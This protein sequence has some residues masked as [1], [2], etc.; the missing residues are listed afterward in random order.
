MKEK[1]DI[2]A[3]MSAV[4]NI[5]YDLSQIFELHILACGTANFLLRILVLLSVTNFLLVSTEI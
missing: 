2:A 5:K 1:K 3:I 4:L